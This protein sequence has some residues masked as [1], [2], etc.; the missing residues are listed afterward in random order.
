VN[1]KLQEKIM[2]DKKT[3][4]LLIEDDKVDQL[5][6]K[7]FVKDAR[8]S[9]SF[10]I[11]GSVGEAKELLDS[12]KFDMAVID[13]ALGDGTAFDVLNSM[14]NI[15]VVFVTGGGGEE[16]A[17]KAM[18]AGAYDYLIKDPERRYLKVLPLIIDNAIKHKKAEMQL[19]LLS[20][21]IR[22]ITDSVYIAD[23]ADKI[24]FVNKTFCK[25]YGYSE[26]EILGKPT[27]HLWAKSTFNENSD[28]PLTDIYNG[29][30]KGETLHR[31]KDGSTFPVSLS[32]SVVVDEKGY[33]IAVVNIAQDITERKRSEEEL[34]RLNRALKTLGACN[35]SLVRAID[36]SSLI[37][38]ICKI[39][40]EIGGYHFAWVGYVDQGLCVRP[41]AKAGCDADYLAAY[42][43][44][45]NSKNKIHDFHPIDKAVRTGKAFVDRNPYRTVD[46]I[47]QNQKQAKQDGVSSIHLPLI[48]EKT[49]L[50]TLNMYSKEA[51]SFDVKEVALLKELAADL[52]FGITNL[53]IRVAHKAAEELLRKSENKYRTLTENINIG[54]YRNTPEPEGKF[55]EVNPAEIQ[56][57]GYENKEE[58]LKIKVSDLYQNPE[59]RKAFNKKLI[60]NGYV[61]DES[62]LLKKKDGT[63]LWCSVTAVVVYDEEGKAAYY[64]GVI[65]DI[66][67][68]R[69]MEEEIEKRKCYLESVLHYTP[70][71]IVT[72]DAY[73]KIIEWNPGAEQIFGFTPD[74]VL[75]KKLDDF[76]AR[77][78]VKAEAIA[79]TNDILSGERILPKET[80]RFRRDGTPINVVVAAS[81]IRI[82]GKLQGGV[83]VYT[84]VTAR[85]R[86]ENELRRV[87]RA[88]KT[89]SEANK[90]LVRATEESDLLSSICKI[91]VEEGKYP[92]AWVGLIEEKKDS[93]LQMS[94][95]AEYGG[96]DDGCLKKMHIDKKDGVPVNNLL[97]KVI[98]TG[99]PCIVKN[100]S[101]E[102]SSI[103]W[104]P[105]AAKRGFASMISLPLKNNGTVFGALTIYA[106]DQEAFDVQEVNLL[107]EMADDLAFGIHVLRAKAAHKKVE[108]EKE[109]IHAQLL[110][111]QKMEAIGILAGGIAHDFNNL[112]TAITGCADM[113][114]LEIDKRSSAYK[115]LN[116]I[117]VAAERAANLTRQ[118]LLFSRK[119][120]MKFELLYLNK[121]IKDL[122]KMLHRLI[123][124]NTV[125]HMELEDNLWMVCADRGSVEQIIMN[126]SINAR[127]A[128]QGLGKLLVKTENVI[129][130]ATQCKQIP[131]AKPGKCVRL[132]VVDNGIGMN[133]ETI[134]H[135]FEPFFSTKEVG[136]GTG[137][138]LSVVY[139]IVK[140]HNG[141]I[142]V[143]SKPGRGSTFEV[144]FPAV[145]EKVQNKMDKSIGL[146]QC[147]GE[148]KRILV[149]E[150]EERV[151]EFTTSGL[152]RSGYVVFSA[153][154]AEEAVR[155][156]EKEKGNFH[157]ILSD[158]GLPGRSGIEL[159]EELVSRQPQLRVLLSSGYTDYKT[160]WPVIQEK[161]F[162][163]LEKPYALT[164]LIHVIRDLDA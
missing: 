126:L 151:R 164:D 125:I 73:Q 127:D 65:E 108:E 36:E 119:Q 94:V 144:Y 134:E 142:R 79:I 56:M 62:L 55:I 32:K 101:Q 117:Q 143:F 146:L 64:D 157:M 7:R 54:I 44:N 159:V 38:G 17:V 68:R 121:V 92:L 70:D 72:F 1:Q 67:K 78:T 20:H 150:D 113:A 139:G 152:Y 90:V 115:D 59:D 16:A 52:A 88:L 46:K 110:H 103:P 63:P 104:Y 141:W 25:T 136:K 81:P 95:K 14:T 153:A 118:L 61:K 133:R 37:H 66:T 21:A 49:I 77:G 91:I 19:A 105:E 58:F 2:E 122:L 145:F 130:N 33:P 34:H 40:V 35:M 82:G 148:G 74:E 22:S 109:K 131:E 28:V 23:T 4:V 47:S 114:K 53:R 51:N 156:F 106:K 163:F 24:I 84:D 8:L 39:L 100:G 124:E 138:G 76:V 10:S 27:H 155:V 6:F 41:Q 160:R 112:L 57:F 132:S 86:A 26:K 111:A 50:G 83:V 98:R 85:K 3:K 129:L 161:G 30:W 99:E 149:V 48:N 162:R 15:P 43:F 71:A 96:Y 137:L 93:G 45:S 120:P 9:Y 158:V 116:E 140:Q 87:N 60:K 31:R 13:Y 97:R 89:L 12:E 18:K 29:G 11:A 123:G 147:R 102:Q 135:I 5:A 128:M 154:N 42:Q 107:K 80:V 69:Q 75:G